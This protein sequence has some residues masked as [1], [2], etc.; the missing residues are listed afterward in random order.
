MNTNDD[1]NENKMTNEDNN[2]NK[3]DNII[4]DKDYVKYKFSKVY[5][6]N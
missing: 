3:M 2:E 6:R 4:N 5:R 1:N